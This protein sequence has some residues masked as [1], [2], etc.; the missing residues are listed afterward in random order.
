[1]AI[2]R[3]FAQATNLQLLGWNGA[4]LAATVLMGLG[5]KFL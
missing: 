5:P 2:S 1:M 3:G 4:W